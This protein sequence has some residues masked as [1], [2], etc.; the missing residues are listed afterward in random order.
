[1]AASV[2]VKIISEVILFMSYSVLIMWWFGAIRDFIS[3]CFSYDFNLISDCIKI[4]KYLDCDI[5]NS[6]AEGSL[7]SKLQTHQSIF[8]VHLCLLSSMHLDDSDWANYFARYLVIA[9]LLRHQNCNF[10]SIVFNFKCHTAQNYFI[11]V[12]FGFFLL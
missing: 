10:E 11:E 12:L 2:E 3:A 8:H 9:V 1:M 7:C 5:F 6:V 4:F